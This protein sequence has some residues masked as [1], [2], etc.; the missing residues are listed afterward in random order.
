M[1]DNVDPD[2]DRGWWAQLIGSSETEQQLKWDSL[3]RDKSKQKAKYRGK[4]HKLEVIYKWWNKERLEQSM[5]KSIWNTKNTNGLEK[6]T[7]FWIMKSAM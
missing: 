3:W 1:S 7:K 5:T 2:L 6:K 4:K